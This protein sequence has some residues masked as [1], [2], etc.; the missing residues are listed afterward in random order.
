MSRLTYA[1]IRTQGSVIGG[2]DSVDTWVKRKMNAW[3]R[4]HYAAYA[5][6]FLISQA[7]G[8]SYAASDS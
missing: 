5:W 4:K 2:N 1:E 3:F 6:P 8:I 7:T